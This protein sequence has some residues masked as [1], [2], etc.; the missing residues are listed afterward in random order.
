MADSSS[1]PATDFV[2]LFSKLLQRLPNFFSVIVTDK[3]GCEVASVHSEERAAEGLE[4]AVGGSLSQ[5]AEQANKLRLG[6]LKSLVAFFE[7]FCF[8]HIAS[9]GSLVVTFIGAK[10]AEVGAALELGNEVR[11]VLETL[12]SKN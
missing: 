9:K 3:D 1:S 5:I 4:S 2:S 8:V 10:D 11:E 12:G 6:R 7:D